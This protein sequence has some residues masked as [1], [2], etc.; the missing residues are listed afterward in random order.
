[1]TGCK[2]SYFQLYMYILCAKFE[3]GQSEDCPV[4]T[5][6]P[7]FV[8]TIC[9]LAIYS[10]THY[11][12]CDMCMLIERWHIIAVEQ[13]TKITFL[14]TNKVGSKFLTQDSVCIKFMYRNALFPDRVQL[15][16]VIFDQVS[17][18]PSYA[19]KRSI[20]DNSWLCSIIFNQVD[21]ALLVIH[22]SSST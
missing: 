19:Q 16:S 6:D 10:P 22:A 20:I 4:Q 3:L 1:M 17:Q 18:L 7:S 21:S 5:L 13:Q 11:F 9:G 12:L 2:L 8:Q 14:S 15:F